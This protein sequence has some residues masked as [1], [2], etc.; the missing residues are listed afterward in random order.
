MKRQQRP[1][2]K[3]TAQQLL[4]VR[5]GY[6]DIDFSKLGRILLRFAPFGKRNLLERLA[7]KDEMAVRS[8]D[9]WVETRG[10]VETYLEGSRWNFFW[11][12]KS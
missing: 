8:W 9:L 10:Y 5:Q 6:T 12:P 7:K 3:Y 11:I 2:D 4:P 1:S